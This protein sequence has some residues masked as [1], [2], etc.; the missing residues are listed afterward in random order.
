M[1]YSN[2]AKKEITPQPDQD[3]CQDPLHKENGTH[4]N[5]KKENHKKNA[6]K[7]MLN[8]SRQFLENE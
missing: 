6:K 1:D 4:G 8:M 3:L 5:S 7:S 2:K